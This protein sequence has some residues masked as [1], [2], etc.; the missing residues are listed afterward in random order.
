MVADT[1]EEYGKLLRCLLN[2]IAIQSD[3]SALF[4]EDAAQLTEAQATKL[5]EILE[6]IRKGLPSETLIALS[7]PRAQERGGSQFSCF[8]D[9]GSASLDKIPLEIHFS[10]LREMR[11]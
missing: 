2:K 11:L 9:F 5:V 4:E 1:F 8:R 7:V 10:S 6:S 3:I